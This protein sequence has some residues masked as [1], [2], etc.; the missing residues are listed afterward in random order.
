MVCDSLTIFCFSLNKMNK[1]FPNNANIY[2]LSLV[3]TESG[4]LIVLDFLQ[5][6][7]IFLNEESVLNGKPSVI[8]HWQT[9]ELFIV[10]DGTI[11]RMWIMFS[12]RSWF[13]E[14]SSFEIERGQWIIYTLL[15]NSLFFLSLHLPVN[16]YSYSTSVPKTICDCWME[17]NIHDYAPLCP[18]YKG[19]ETIKCVCECAWP[20]ACTHWPCLCICGDESWLYIDSVNTNTDSEIAPRSN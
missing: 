19:S 18:L 12:P 11:L 2:I 7:F 6:L 20:E 3:G 17:L 1:H 10:L 8:K 9:K 15:I 4:C 13:Y 14:I 16:T 5:F